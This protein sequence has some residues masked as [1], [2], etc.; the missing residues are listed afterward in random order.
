MKN[1]LIAVIVA[2]GIVMGVAVSSMAQSN[3]TFGG[4]RSTSAD[5]I[6]SQPG[7]VDMV[8]ITNNG[9][10]D[11]SLTLCDST[12]FSGCSTSN[13][14]FTVLTCSAVNGTTCVTPS[15]LNAGF[16]YGLSVVMSG[17]GCTYN[18]RGRAGR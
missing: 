10:V 1:T 13:Q 6:Y 17:A 7:T 11:C 9:V 14:L 16:T 3:I 15:N 5:S 12:T 2:M 8:S 4:T 18:V